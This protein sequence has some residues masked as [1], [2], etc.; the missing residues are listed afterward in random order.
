MTTEELNMAIETKKEIIRLQSSVDR[1]RRTSGISSSL[2]V[3]MVK[4][5][6]KQNVAQRILE[7]ESE[8]KELSERLI[9]EQS[10]IKFGIKKLSLPKLEE[11]ILIMR[12]S[13]VEPWELISDA[14]GYSK[15]H[16]FMCHAAILKKI[17]AD[18]T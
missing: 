14:I 1:L 6:I 11:K 16:T 2:G 18:K 13:D 17:I 3:E 5:G 10:I 15:S 12:Y 8:I 4:G 7:N 9:V